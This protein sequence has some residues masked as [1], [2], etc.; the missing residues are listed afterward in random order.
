MAR[1][2]TQPSDKTQH[3]HTCRRRRLRCDGVRPTCNKC[4][5]RG[6]D[7]LGYGAQA[8]LWVQPQSS[9]DST[10]AA[11]KQ[12]RPEE[13]AVAAETA[14]GGRRKGRPKLVLMPRAASE[15]A[16][17]DGDGLELT[18]RPGTASLDAYRAVMRMRGF[19]EEN[20]R[21]R[22]IVPSPGLDPEGYQQQRLLIDSLR[23]CI[24]T[25]HYHHHPDTRQRL[26]L[27]DDDHVCS[28][29]VLFDTPKNPFRVLL[30]FW[31]YLPDV[32]AD[33]LVS[34]AAVHRIS[35]TQSALEVAAYV[36]GYRYALRDGG[37][38]GGRLLAVRHP[39]V[40]VVFRHQQRMARALAAMV[41]DPDA[42]A[43]RGLLEVV[44]TVM[45]CQVQ[46]SLF[47]DWDKHLLGAQAVIAARGG[48][49]SF[50]LEKST[51]VNFDICTVMQ[52]E[53]MRDI[54]TPA[55]L[56]RPRQA[57]FEDYLEYVIPIYQEGW[58]SA[59]PCTNFLMSCL[60]RISM[61]RYDDHQDSAG[62]A[63]RL[64][65]RR[66]LLEDILAFS[67][68][69]WLDSR[70]ARLAEVFGPRAKEAEGGRTRAALLDLIRSFH[71]STV[72]YAVRT[73][74]LDRGVHALTGVGDLRLVE[75]AAVETLG[76]SLRRVWET[77][78]AA[79]D[80]FGKF[81]IWPL[82]VLGMS[83]DPVAEEPRG[84]GTKDFICKSLLRL[85]HHIG[86]MAYKDAI[87]ALQHTWERD[88]GLERPGWLEA[89]PLDVLP[90]LF[91]M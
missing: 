26:T 10:G 90:G 42:R 40:P 25:A 6:V 36:P 81:T 30:E 61:A 17:P 88:G 8:L 43:Q 62:I 12:Q 39:L 74:L 44:T 52:V 58:L 72:L 49:K 50:A 35:K 68:A 46:Q 13:P 55:C 5:V 59:F 20:L 82:F 24:Y 34:I 54:G 85:G 31:S 63:A 84:E 3:C 69:D 7:C 64:P 9:S 78:R 2:E 87:W 86:S 91:F 53:V 22:S 76:A 89:L 56:L 71:M 27:T 80:W 21:R 1:K 41:A 65:L 33:P 23:Y 48:I 37:D 60:M 4:V 66:Q 15:L 29:L 47:G 51:P 70:A 38:S 19:R 18:R 75:A 67:P 73:L 45:L 77:E 28:D 14:V 11:Q 83:V 32:V 57:M 16:M 79:P